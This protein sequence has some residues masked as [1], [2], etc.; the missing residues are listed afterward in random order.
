MV[1]SLP[2]GDDVS[3]SSS[4]GNITSRQDHDW[5]ILRVLKDKLQQLELYE[6]AVLGEAEATGRVQY[7]VRG[8]I[9]QL[10]GLLEKD[11]ALDFPPREVIP[12]SRK[13]DMFSVPSKGMSL[14]KMVSKL[15]KDSKMCDASTQT[16]ADRILQ[17]VM[18]LEP[19]SAEELKLETM[20]AKELAD[21]KRRMKEEEEEKKKRAMEEFEDTADVDHDP[22]EEEDELKKLPSF[23]LTRALFKTHE[24]RPPLMEGLPDGQRVSYLFKPFMVHAMDKRGDS[25]KQYAYY[26]DDANDM[27]ER[28]VARRLWEKRWRRGRILRHYKGP[29]MQRVPPFIR[30]IRRHEEALA[31]RVGQLS[32]MLREAKALHDRLDR[33]LE[34]VD[35]AGVGLPEY[36]DSDDESNDDELILDFE[37]DLAEGSAASVTYPTGGQSFFEEGSLLHTNSVGS[38]ASPVNEAGNTMVRLSAKPVHNTYPFITHNLTTHASPHNTPAHNTPAHNTPTDTPAHNTPYFITHP[39]TTSIL[40]NTFSQYAYSQ[41]TLS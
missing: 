14:G 28:A 26:I 40:R 23:E 41:H 25:L 38:L 31:Q 1:A 10:N 19:V 39:L 34:L 30:Y 8:F 13:N 29:L 35:L 17:R 18:Q 32:V 12:F 4:R 16:A 20:K 37:Q 2:A 24:D 3:V 7:R 11:V 5:G 27:S 6:A 36:E 33:A 15:I 21:L 22:A 9:E